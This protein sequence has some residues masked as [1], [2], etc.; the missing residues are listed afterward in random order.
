MNILIPCEHILRFLHP[1]RKKNPLEVIHLVLDD[2]GSESR[3]E[4]GL[5]PKGG[6]DIRNLDSLPSIHVP[7][8]SR[9][10]QTPLV[11]GLGLFGMF[12]D[13]RIYHRDRPIVFIVPIAHKTHGD[14]PFI[15]PNLR[16][17]KS[18]PAIVRI[19]HIPHH[20][21]GKAH[22]FPEFRWNDRFAFRSED[23]VGFAG[24]DGEVHRIFVQSR[25][26]RAIIGKIR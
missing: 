26:I 2:A 8:F 1:I 7:V 11:I 18:N 10:T 16:S 12:Y 24:L 23:P 22:V 25:I 15:H 14:N 4:Y 9:D 20:I 17:S 21:L 5:W 6:I 3:E 13:F 19:F